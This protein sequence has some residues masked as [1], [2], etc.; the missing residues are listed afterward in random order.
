M[1]D[2]AKEAELVGPDQHDPLSTFTPEAMEEA[3]GLSPMHLMERMIEVGLTTESAAAFEKLSGL[4][5]RWA[6]RGAEKEFTAAFAAFHKE[7][8]AIPKSRTADVMKDGR[9]Q[10]SYDYANLDDCVR[11]CGPYLTKHGFSWSFSTVPPDGGKGLQEAC[12][13]HHIGGHS[14]TSHSPVLPTDA[15]SPGMGPQQK[16]GNAQT[17]ARRYAFTGVIGKSPG[18]ADPDEV[19]QDITTID[20]DQRIEL[21]ALLAETKS[22]VPRFCKHFGCELVQD[23]A[24]SEFPKAKAMLKQKLKVMS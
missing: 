8:P 20:D 23:L 10:Y 2:D 5:E 19:P 3:T 11:V 7:C 4:A 9:K 18:D 21:D 13:L 12:T 14:V 22:D 17:Y 6:D 24:A 16:A 15:Q 1:T